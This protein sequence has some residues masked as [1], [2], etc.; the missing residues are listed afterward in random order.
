MGAGVQERLRTRLETLEVRIA[1]AF[2]L[3]GE[4]ELGVQDYKNFYRLLGSYRGLSESG[5]EYIRIAK[6]IDWVQWQEAR[7]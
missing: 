5:L 7:F 2:R 4:G 3:A 1:E 6:Q